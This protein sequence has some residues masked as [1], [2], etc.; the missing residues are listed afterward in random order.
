MLLHPPVSY[1]HHLANP[2]Q[3]LLVTRTEVGSPHLGLPNRRHLNMTKVIMSFN[4][5]L[6]YYH[7]YKCYFYYYVHDYYLFLNC[8]PVFNVVITELTI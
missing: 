4:M 1:H 6:Y 3:G 8:F 7:Y 5:L 2:G